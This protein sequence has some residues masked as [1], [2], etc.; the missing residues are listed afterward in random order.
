MTKTKAIAGVIAVFLLGAAAGSLISMRCCRH[1]DFKGV[2]PAEAIV[3]RLDKKLSLDDAQRTQIL[4][5]V[6]DTQSQ[7]QELRK[8]SKP[9]MD[10]IFSGSEEKVRAVLRP[11]QRVKYEEVIA[12]WK[13]RRERE[14]HDGQHEGR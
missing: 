3:K 10:A 2:P 5:I 11:D 6:T 1:H 7:M 14:D 9:K 13:E 8:E 4:K 12:K